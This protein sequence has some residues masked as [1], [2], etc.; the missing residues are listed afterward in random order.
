VIAKAFKKQ[1][2]ASENSL[3]EVASKKKCD[4]ENSLKNQVRRRG[5]PDFELSA[6]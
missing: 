5:V 6:A 2:D 3:N 1:F 4:G